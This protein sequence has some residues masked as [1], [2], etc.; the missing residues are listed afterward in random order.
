VRLSSPAAP[1]SLAIGEVTHINPRINVNNR[2]IEVMVE[3]DNP[4][5][6]YPG[7]T[8]DATLVVGSSVGALTLP[9]LSVIKRDVGRV[10]FVSTGDTVEQRVVELGW[11]EIDWVEVLSGVAADDQVVVQGAALMSNGSRVQAMEHKR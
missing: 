1:D 10:I 4:G 2:A 11:R 5:G 6:W 7:A 8:V 9:A 3:F